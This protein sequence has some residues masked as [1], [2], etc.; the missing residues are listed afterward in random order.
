M[1]TT[2][3][4]L[5]IG[6]IGANIGTSL[7][8]AL[9]MREADEHGLVGYRYELIELAEDADPGTAMLAAV[10]D[11]FDG[12]NIT[13]PFKQSVMTVLDELSDEAR[14]LG[15]V[16][17]VIVSDGKL[18][19]HNTDHTGF[20]TAL[21]L[22]LPGAAKNRVTLVG[23][24]GAGS[25]VAFALA[26]AGVAHLTIADVAVDRATDLV[27]RVSAAVPADIRAIGLD[28]VA[29][30]IEAADGIVNATPIGMVG[31]PGLPI[32][33]GHLRPSQWVADII[34]RPIETE[35]IRAAVRS[36]C[37]VLDGGQML[38]AQ[39]AASFDLF[40]G[41]SA[42]VARMRGHLAHL[43]ARLPAA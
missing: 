19:G 27:S 43:I 28:Q 20:G 22:G 4:P 24:G 39:A 8:P 14:A 37:R 34:Y 31:H 17:T 26:H 13:H 7:S 3:H 16:N 1:S 41:T 2:G 42:D 5:R 36:G 11:G 10:A 9:H 33:T 29:P 15:A 18:V 35:L 30:T 12:F 38:V 6:L 40:T 23:A 32:P 21:A 25:A